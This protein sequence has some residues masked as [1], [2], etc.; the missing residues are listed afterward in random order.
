MWLPR[1]SPPQGRSRRRSSRPRGVRDWQMPW[2][3]AAAALGQA[4]TDRGTGA[5]APRS[6]F[7]TS[8]ATP[9][10]QA[11][12]N[13]PPSH[14]AQAA[15][16]SPLLGLPSLLSTG[17]SLSGH[18]HR[19]ETPRPKP[20]P[21]GQEGSSRNQPLPTAS[22][23]RLQ[24]GGH[25]EQG[26][27]EAAGRRAPRAG[28]TGS[29]PTLSCGSRKLPAQPLDPGAPTRGGGPGTEPGRA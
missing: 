7:P 4:G 2:E 13:S 12:K 28:Q 17:P 27:G 9:G 1:G 19:T 14:Q 20:R 25:P 15:H 21:H 22:P 8:L 16:P 11:V 5:L 29:Q 3:G 6:R 23:V 10:L 26:T 18:W 24:V